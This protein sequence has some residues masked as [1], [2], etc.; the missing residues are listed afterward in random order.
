MEVLLKV[1]ITEFDKHIYNSFLKVTR[2]AKNTPFKLRKDFTKLDENIFVSLKRLSSF[3]KRFPN[4]K[5]EDFFSAPYRLYKDETFFPLEFYTSLKATKAYTLTQKQLAMTDPDNPEQIKFIKESIVFIYNFCKK[6]NIQINQYLNH[7]TNNE[8]S[9]ILH[10]RDR[11]ISVYILFGFS[12]IDS[13]IKSKD[14][15][16]LKF[17]IGEDFYNNFFVFK[18]KFLNSKRALNLVTLGLQKISKKIVER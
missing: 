7:R 5:I 12:G 3:F 10:L 9:F 1:V 14:S 2:S 16:V 8:Y 6:Y 11:K 13:I 4:I 15:E 17:I 18:T